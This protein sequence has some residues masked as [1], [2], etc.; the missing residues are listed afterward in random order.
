[1][2]ETLENDGKGAGWFLHI[3]GEDPSV[4]K[5]NWLDLGEPTHTLVSC[6]MPKPLP[7]R[8]HCTSCFAA[9]NRLHADILWILYI[10]LRYIL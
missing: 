6:R 3:I 7:P 9:A 10:N 5:S 2:L 4:C 8:N 1:M